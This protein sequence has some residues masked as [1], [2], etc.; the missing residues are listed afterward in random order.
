MACPEGV[1]P[2][3][4]SASASGSGESGAGHLPH[5]A[6]SAGKQ[7][8]VPDLPLGAGPHGGTVWLV[9]V[10]L[11]PAGCPCAAV[12]VLLQ[13][14]PWSLSLTTGPFS[15]LMTPLYFPQSAR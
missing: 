3:A 7:E 1:T 14:G 15:F 8:Q 4:V 9:L 2:L 5:A 10:A 13:A 12:A 6:C 11:L